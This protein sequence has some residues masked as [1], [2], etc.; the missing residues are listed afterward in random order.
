MLAWIPRLVDTTG[1]RWARLRG[2]RVHSAGLGEAAVLGHCSEHGAP[3]SSA[4][5]LCCCRLSAPSPVCSVRWTV[6]YSPVVG[7]RAT[8]C[9]CTGFDSGCVGLSGADQEGIGSGAATSLAPAEYRCTNNIV[10]IGAVNVTSRPCVASVSRR[11]GHPCPTLSSHTAPAPPASN[12]PSES[13]L[14]LRRC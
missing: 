5:W 6:A 9:L 11:P 3:L 13:P 10:T 14:C 12:M 7:S 4:L 2:H 8:T 1:Q